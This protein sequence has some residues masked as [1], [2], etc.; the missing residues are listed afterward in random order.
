M[1]RPYAVKFYLNETIVGGLLVSVPTTC[2]TNVSLLLAF[3]Y[4]FIYGSVRAF[5]TGNSLYVYMHQEYGTA[6]C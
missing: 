2:N 5:D 6:L 4:L 3:V 1:R